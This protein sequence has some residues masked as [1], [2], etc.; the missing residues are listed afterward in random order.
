MVDAEEEARLKKQLFEE[1]KKA[2]Q[3]KKIVEVQRVDEN[4][5]VIEE[6]DAKKDAAQDAEDA[7]EES[8]PIKY[9]PLGSETCPVDPDD[10]EIDYAMNFRIPKIENLENC[11][12][13]RVSHALSISLTTNFFYLPISV[14]GIAQK[15]NQAHRRF[16][17][18][19]RPLRDRVL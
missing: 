3:G 17:E 5:N 1:K 15:L 18:Q 7:K 19:H 6:D 13:L 12:K 4:G 8:Q 14:L 16:G 2:W 10:E 9:T 11:T